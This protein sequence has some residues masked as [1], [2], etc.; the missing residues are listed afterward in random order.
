[1]KHWGSEQLLTQFKFIGSRNSQQTFLR[2]SGGSALQVVIINLDHHI[3]K[4]CCSVLRIKSSHSK[5]PHAQFSVLTVMCKFILGIVMASVCLFNSLHET[6]YSHLGSGVCCRSKASFFVLNLSIQTQSRT[7]FIVCQNVLEPKAYPQ[8]HLR[9]WK[10]IQ[11]MQNYQGSCL[12]GEKQSA[13]KLNF[14]LPIRPQPHTRLSSG[15]LK[16]I[17]AVSLQVAQFTT[18]NY[19]FNYCKII[20]QRI[21]RFV[22]SPETGSNL[23]KCW[24][25]TKIILLKT[26]RKVL[27]SR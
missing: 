21:T 10:I 1:M 27:R 17:L 7:H 3:I 22:K 9:T 13:W 12:P 20:S 15:I 2:L 11:S 6:Y 26:G 18:Y 23:R 8:N 5:S 19:E 24:E 16:T 14:T 4:H 25:N